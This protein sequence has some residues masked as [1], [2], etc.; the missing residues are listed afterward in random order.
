MNPAVKESKPNPNGLPFLKWLLNP[1]QQLFSKKLPYPMWPLHLRRWYHPKRVLRNSALL[2]L[3]FL[4][5]GIP[6]V[7][8]KSISATGEQT[9]GLTTRVDVTSSL[10]HPVENAV[11]TITL[12]DGYGQEGT[13]RQDEHYS[14][15]HQY[16]GRYVNERGFRGGSNETHIR[17]AAPDHETYSEMVSWSGSVPTSISVRLYHNNYYQRCNEDLDSGI[18]SRIPFL[19]S[20]WEDCSVAP[21][22]LIETFGVE[23]KNFEN[24]YTQGGQGQFLW[25]LDVHKYAPKMDN[26]VAGYRLRYLAYQAILEQWVRGS[27]LSMAIAN[28]RE[29]SEW[30]DQRRTRLR[31]IDEARFIME[32]TSFVSE[33]DVFFDEFKTALAFVGYGFRLASAHEEGWLDAAMNFLAYQSAYGE[34]LDRIEELV[35]QSDSW[36]ADD[37]AFTSA[38]SNTRVDYLVNRDREMEQVARAVISRNV[39]ETVGDIIMGAAL[40]KAISAS[41]S[42]AIVTGAA[43]SAA[44][45]GVLAA[46]AAFTVHDF[47]SSVD[48]TAR[49]RAFLA[50][51]AQMDRYLLSGSPDIF[52]ALEVR[53]MSGQEQFDILLRLQLGLIFNQARAALYAGDFKTWIGNQFAYSDDGARNKEQAYELRKSAVSREKMERAERDID[54]LLRAMM[55]DE[56]IV[57]E[58]SYALHICDVWTVANS[59][60][61]EG[62]ID[63]WDISMLPHNVL[64]DVRFNMFRIPDQLLMEYP[65]GNTVLDTGWRGDRSFNNN[66]SYPGGIRGGG[67]GEFLGVFQKEVMDEFIVRVNGVDSGTKWNYS[68]RCRMP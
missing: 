4:F 30:L 53:Q 65:P 28:N 55:Q 59:G 12:K 16:G 29:L 52:N 56:I 60:G 3:F 13:I 7:T 17:V 34:V 36:I 58:R 22:R 43:G 68:V 40:K 44:V 64:L 57:E 62:T 48:E 26:H 25:N 54:L 33:F 67:Q 38:L 23:K 20:R 5:G 35:R 24:S 50:A 31:D 45:A 46:G 11:V 42:A 10:G 32:A 51:A 61:V 47:L 6:P 14:L 1:M 19:S 66:P 15:T 8:P 63:T 39:G 41:V 27:A 2:V 37:N 9:A 18:L 21:A 49:Q